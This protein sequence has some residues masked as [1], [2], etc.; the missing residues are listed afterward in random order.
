MQ[1]AMEKAIVIIPGKP[2]RAISVYGSNIVALREEDRESWNGTIKESRNGAII[3]EIHVKFNI[4]E[5]TTTMIPLGQQMYRGEDKKQMIMCGDIENPITVRGPDM[6]NNEVTPDFFPEMAFH[7]YHPG[8]EEAILRIGYVGA[9]RKL[10]W[11]NGLPT[12]AWDICPMVAEE[13]ILRALPRGM[14]YKS[15][16]L[17]IKF[18]YRGNEDKAETTLYALVQ[19][20]NNV[21]RAVGRR[22]NTGTHWF[23]VED[24]LEKNKGWSIILVAE[25]EFNFPQ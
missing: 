9:V 3:D 14:D 8:R 22:L 10:T 12:G 16:I 20:T 18:H 19:G 25:R 21:W 15:P 23:D 24:D 17:E 7:Y 1:T 2:A 4:D 13:R 11:R 6:A 5:K